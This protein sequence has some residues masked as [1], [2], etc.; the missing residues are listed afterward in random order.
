MT[1]AAY[2][3]LF[4]GAFSIAAFTC[5]PSLPPLNTESSFSVPETL[6][7]ISLLE[8]IKFV[9]SAAVLESKFNIATSNSAESVYTFSL[10]SGFLSM[11]FVSGDTPS[12]IVASVPGNSTGSFNRDHASSGFNDANPVDILSTLNVFTCL[13]PSGKDANALFTVLLIWLVTCDILSVANPLIETASNA[14]IFPTASLPALIN[15]L[16]D[17][18]PTI[19]C[20]SPLKLA[21]R[22]S[23]LTLTA[24]VA[25]SCRLATLGGNFAPKPVIRERTPEI[26]LELLSASR[27]ATTGTTIPVTGSGSL[28]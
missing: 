24:S 21:A 13:L 23:E 9:I 28:Y 15:P 2:A 11:F 18:S 1:E 4:T 5:A 7:L 10:P 12:Y 6:S 8:G 14:P 22:L 25:R 27:L 3:S 26:V 17:T 19:F 16:G 20:K